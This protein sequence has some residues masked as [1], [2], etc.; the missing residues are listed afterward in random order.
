MLTPYAKA[1]ITLLKIDRRHRALV[2]K[3][4][5]NLDRVAWVSHSTALFVGDKAVMSVIADQ[6]AFDCIHATVG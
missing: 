3:L 4:S 5:P 6:K 2:K 1:H